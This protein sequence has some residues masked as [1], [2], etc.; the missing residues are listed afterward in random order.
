MNE[1]TAGRI[2]WL[3]ARI[4]ALNGERER[5]VAELAVLTAV[6][7]APPPVSAPEIEAPAVT[8]ASSP[9]DKVRL[10]LS[11]FRGRTDVFPRRWE[12]AKGSIRVRPTSPFMVESIAL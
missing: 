5:L 7:E 8:N 12:N 10:F 1:T 3:Q 2:G 4:A 6:R 11:L 9:E